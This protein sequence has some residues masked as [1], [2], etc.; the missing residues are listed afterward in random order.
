MRDEGWQQ[1]KEGLRDRMRNVMKVTK[2]QKEDNKTGCQCRVCFLKR[3]SPWFNGM[4]EIMWSAAWKRI[5]EIHESHVMQREQRASVHMIQESNMR[6]W[7]EWW[8]ETQETRQIQMQIVRG[9]QDHIQCI[10]LDVAAWMTAVA[11]LINW[12]YAILS[13]VERRYPEPQNIIFMG[14]NI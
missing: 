11:G 12:Y 3:R 10:G 6:K 5:S 4:L 8:A 13:A 7:S 1:R 2:W 14:F 9:S